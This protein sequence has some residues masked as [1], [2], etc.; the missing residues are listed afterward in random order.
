MSNLI[1]ASQIAYSETVRTIDMNNRAEGYQQ[2]FM[3]KCIADSIASRQ[4]EL[5]EVSRKLESERVLTQEDVEFTPG[6]V[7]EQVF[8][9]EEEAENAVTTLE[10]RL[11][12]K[13]NELKEAEKQIEEAKAEAERLISEAG[14]EAESIIAAA[15]ADAEEEARAVLETARQEGLEQ[16][17]KQAEEEHQRALAELEET[18]QQCFAEYEQRVAELEP[19][20]VELVLKYV[21][22]LTGIYAEDKKDIIIYLI[23]SAMKNKHGS[24]NFI[25]RVSEADFAMASYTRDSVRAYLSDD[26]TVEV[27]ADKM[28]TKNQCMIETE[29]RIFDCSLDGQMLSLIEDVRMLAEKD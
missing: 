12:E 2:E 14:T 4:A 29:S 21:R 1:K 19:A 3:D 5:E 17:L 24:D 25:I 16:G 7:M 26:A 8:T 15:H 13:K 11:I 27:V 18:R 22:K 6:L 9:E 10:S 23:D 28:L 20:F